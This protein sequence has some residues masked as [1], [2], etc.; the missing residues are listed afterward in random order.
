MLF[1]CSEHEEPRIGEWDS[2]KMYRIGMTTERIGNGK[3]FQVPA[4]G[5]SY[6][7]ACA[8]YEYF[9]VN[10]IAQDDKY[11]PLPKEHSIVV[12]NG[13]WDVAFAPNTTGKARRFEY[14][15]QAGD[16]FFTINFEQAA[17]PPR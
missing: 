6:H 9:W 3:T 7:F 12:K 8:N 14:T 5:A 1:S 4:A 17:M 11:L 10:S 15:L 13:K 16:T 2:M